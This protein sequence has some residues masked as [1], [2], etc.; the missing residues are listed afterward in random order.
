MG[1]LAAAMRTAVWFALVGAC[2]ED[3]GPRTEYIGVSG[4]NV[5]PIAVVSDG[6]IIGPTLALVP[7]RSGYR[8]MADSAILDLRCD[9]QR[10]VGTMRDRMVELHYW[11]VDDVIRVRGMLAG[12]MGRLEASNFAI[13]STL[14]T[15][16]Y[17]LE[18]TGDHYQGLR[19][20][21]IGVRLPVV[22]PIEVALPPHFARLPSERQAM[23]LAILFS[24]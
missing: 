3:S 21:T 10:I 23:L 13:K 4:K 6:Q 16:S 14:G 18:A 12:R 1:R 15:C 8:G 17:E 5:R 22:R 7:T 20:C 19:A 24:D 2:A 11:V 9:G